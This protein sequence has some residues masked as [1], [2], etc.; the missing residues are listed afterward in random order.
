[1]P[2]TDARSGTKT[3]L[4]IDDDPDFTAAIRSVLE[5]EGYAVVEARSGAEGLEKLRAHEPDL[6]VLDVMM[7]SSTEGYGVSETIKY[8]EQYRAFD[9]TPIIMVSSIHE[10]PDERYPRAPEVDMIRPD[11]YLTKPLDIPAFLEIVRK[12]LHR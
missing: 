1:M 2:A 10:S 5:H 11:R 6:V 12:T 8:S 3:I 4:V 7:E 9:S